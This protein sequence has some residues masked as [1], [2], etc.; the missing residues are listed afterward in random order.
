MERKQMW[1]PFF[2]GLV[3]PLALLGLAIRQ[4]EP[5]P[6][7]TTSAPIETT[8]TQPT[9][10]PE[11]LLSVLS[12][13][14]T[15]IEMPLEEYLLGVVLSEM[16]ADFHLEALKAQTVVARTYTMKRLDEGKHKKASVCMDSS[17]CQG[18]RSEADYYA[19][20]GSAE[21]VEKIAQAVADT[22]GMVLTY[23]GELIDATYFSCSGGSTE[24][25]VAVWGTDVP[26][27]QAVDSPGEE[28]AVHFDDQVVF[29]SSNFAAKL[30]IDPVGGPSGW[31]GPV[32]YTQGGGVATMEICGTT[33]RGT[34]LRQLLGLRSTAFS[35][36][37]EGDKIYVDTRGYGHRVGMSQYG[38]QAMAEQGSTFREILD[39]YYQGTTLEE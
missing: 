33:Y 31:F 8:Q 6:P 14:G 20:G 34:E 2:Y 19:N 35:V 25:A 18:Y 27:L 16:P 23:N 36:T 22:S 7:E 30:G 10:Q 37:V 15:V 12:Q 29:T 39:Y 38:A 4:Q 17:C 5:L 32:T 21:S 26:Y 1:V 11:E 28:D 13:D 9:Q 24:A 3:L